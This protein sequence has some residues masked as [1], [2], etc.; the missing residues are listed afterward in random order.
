CKLGYDGLHSARAVVRCLVQDDA[1]DHV[2]PLSFRVLFDSARFGSD[3]ISNFPN[4]TTTRLR[5]GDV[6]PERSDPRKRSLE[7]CAVAVVRDFPK[8]KL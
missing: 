4:Y 5:R 7:G 1:I 6:S 2:V 8:K 3:F